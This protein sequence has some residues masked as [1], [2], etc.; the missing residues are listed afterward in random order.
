MANHTHYD[1]LRVPRDA[2]GDVIRAAYK[3]LIQQYASDQNPSAD[4]SRLMKVI[5]NSYSILSNP[6]QKNKYDQWLLEQES[7]SIGMKKTGSG[8]NGG[9]AA[10]NRSNIYPLRPVEIPAPS[11]AAIDNGGILDRTLV[12]GT[13]IADIPDNREGKKRGGW[14]MLGTLF[15][16]VLTAVA[17]FG[18]SE[19]AVE[20]KAQEVA[21]SD[22]AVAHSGRSTATG[23][24]LPVPETG[25]GSVLQS[26]D[27]PAHDP[28]EIGRFI[29]KWK[30]VDD[31]AAVQQSLDIS[32]KSERSFVFRLDSKAGRDIGGLYGVADF[33]AGYARFHNKEYGCSIVFTIKSDVLQVGATGCQAFYRNRASFSGDYRR[34]GLAKPDPKPAPAAPKP[35]AAEIAV[36]AIG[37]TQPEAPPPTAAK[38]AP[39]LRKYAATVR[40]PDGGTMTIELLAKDKDAARA[41]IRDFRGNPKVVKL[42]ELKN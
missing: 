28:V 10:G 42:K 32:P 2:S 22:D 25:S 37:N 18:S 1:N 38:P 14:L 36:N 23:P 9:Q 4:A 7:E 6:I 13:E 3:E 5:H 19:N 17:W 11:P 24:T 33:E 12:A 35:A 29:G 8:G 16:L 41:I 40:N 31:V 20:R 39:K 15:M 26:A 34:P 27:I 30:G 21:V